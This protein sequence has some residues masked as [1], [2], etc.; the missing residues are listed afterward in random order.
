MQPGSFSRVLAHSVSR[1]AFSVILYSAHYPFAA[2]LCVEKGPLFSFAGSL[3]ELALAYA[4]Q[5]A[6][7]KSKWKAQVYDRGTL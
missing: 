3:K 7:V 4:R 6:A 2:G 5:N 1:T